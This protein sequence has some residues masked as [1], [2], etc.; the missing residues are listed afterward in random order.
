MMQNARKATLWPKFG[1][2][3]DVESQRQETCKIVGESRD[4]KLNDTAPKIHTCGTWL[5]TKQ[6]C[7]QIVC[8]SEIGVHFLNVCQKL[9][10]YFHPREIDCAIK[11][12]TR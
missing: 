8:H 3:D 5:L 11:T 6:S 2:H 12:L 7:Y 1:V 10:Q 9:E 4:G